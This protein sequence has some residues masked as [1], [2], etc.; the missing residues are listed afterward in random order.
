MPIIS[1]VFE[2]EVFRQFY[3]YFSDNSILSKF[4]SGFRPLHSTVSALIQMCDDWFENMDNGKLTGVIFIDIRKAFDSIDHSILL[5]TSSNHRLNGAFYVKLF[6]L[7]YAGIIY[8]HS[9]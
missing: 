3:L 9:I 7:D 6:S 2:K 4:Q 5:E 8:L 1:K